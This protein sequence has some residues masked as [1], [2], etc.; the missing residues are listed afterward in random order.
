MPSFLAPLV[1][2]SAARYL[3]RN[4]RTNR[5]LATR[6]ETAFDSRQRRRGLLDRTH[7]D[8]DAAMVLAPCAAVHTFFMRFPIDVVFVRRNGTVAGVVSNV[9]PWRIAVAPRAFAAIELAPGAAAYSGT[10]RGDRL[11]LEFIESRSGETPG[12]PSTPS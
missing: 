9:K 12:P 7:L 4:D 2:G 1:D 6:L 10:M 5:T 11:R 8:P 3:L